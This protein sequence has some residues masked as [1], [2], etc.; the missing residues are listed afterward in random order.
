MS[1]IRNVY[2]FLMRQQKPFKVNIFRNMLQNLSLG[3]TQQYQSIYIIAL[4][5]TA[6]ELGYV[7]S[8][9]GVATILLSL[10]IGVLADRLGIKR[11]MT[12]SLLL[13]LVG[14]VA[15]G[16]AQSWQSTAIAYFLTAFALVI[17][18]TV[19]PMVCGTCLRSI[20]RTTGM[21]ICDTVV[22][23]P[24]LFAPISAAL[25]ITYFGGLNA[26]GIRPLYWLN[27]GVFAL[28][29]LIILRFFENPQVA[30]QSDGVGSFNGLVR[31]F[32]EGVKV[33][34]WLVYSTLTS[35]PWYLSFYVPLYARQVKNADSFVLGLMDSGFWLIVVLLALPVGQLS[36]RLG[37]KRVI[38]FLTPVYCLGL[39]ML[40]NSPSQLVTIIA[41]ALCGFVTLSGV[42]EGSLTVELV[43]REL[44][45]S[46]YGMLGLFGGLVSFAG[47]IIGG[48][49]W[50][51][52]PI[53]VLYL[54]AATQILK[55]SILWTMPSKTKYS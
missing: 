54:L 43:P 1:A 11:M 50:G 35:L 15:F 27:A 5:A 8:L 24:R 38:M 2:K 31:V 40:G 37:R 13:F 25:I 18:S 32:R 14:Y 29:T 47:P 55:L 34:R 6:L 46:W 36:D 44:L 17:G 23:I 20:E 39:I 41:G 52:D 19:C 22:A 3:L 9:G 48:I 7:T 42:T 30:K 4:G 53:W 33:K 16:L 26:D 45:G 28:A 10:P 49:I 21:Q 12:T 51:L